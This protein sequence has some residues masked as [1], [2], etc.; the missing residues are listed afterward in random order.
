MKQLARTPQ[1]IGVALQRKRKLK[2]FSQAQLAEKIGVGQDK[3]SRAEA[4]NPGLRLEM[5]CK[6]LAALD[7]ELIVAPRGSLSNEV[8]MLSLFQ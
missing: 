1:Q 5:L 4:G 6:L 8:D 3:I 2:K 7:L